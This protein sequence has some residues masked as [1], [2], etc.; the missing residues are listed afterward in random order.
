M[1]LLLSQTSKLF[2]CSINVAKKKKKKEKA[3]Q[4]EFNIKYTTEESSEVM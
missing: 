3:E 1:K 4:H 2:V